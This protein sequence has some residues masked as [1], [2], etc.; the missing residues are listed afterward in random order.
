MNPPPVSWGQRFPAIKLSLLFAVAVFFIHFF[1]LSSEFPANH[2]LIFSLIAIGLLG[3]ACF[4]LQY[5][6]DVSMVIPLV[7]LIAAARMPT[8]KL[9]AEH[10]AHF[11]D[12][13]KPVV[14][15]GIIASD[16][17]AN[18][19]KTKVVMD[20]NEIRLSQNLFFKTEGKVLLTL[21]AGGRKPIA[22]GDELEVYG[23]LLKPR[24]ERNPG[25][26][27]YRAYLVRQ[28]IWGLMYIRDSTNIRSTGKN[29][30]NPFFSRFVLPIKHYVMRLNE[31]QLSP[32][33]A[34]VLTGLLVGERSEIP[35]EVIQAFSL[36]GTIHILSL[37]GLHVVFI[38]ALLLGI[39]SFLRIPYGW[40]IGMTIV[41]LGIY[42]CIGEFVP[43]VVRAALMTTVVLAGGLLQRRR[44]IV[45]SLFV[46]LLIILFFD[47]LSLFDIGLQLSF[48]AVLSIVLFY[49]KLESASKRIGFF[50]KP[51]MDFKDKVW[52]LLM[53][54]VAAQIG[55]VPFSAYYF[56]KIPLVALVSNVAVVPLSS[57]AM[58]LGFFAAIAGAFSPIMS[59][60]YAHVN[61]YVIWLMIQIAQWSSKWPLAYVEYYQLNSVGLV[62]FYLFLF[63]VMNWSN[64]VI[65]KIGLI[66]TIVVLMIFMWK[67]VFWATPMRINFL[68]VGQGD[69][70]VI[71]LPGGKTMVVDAGD[72]EPDFDNGEKIVAPF[73][74][75][76]GITTID[77]LVMS[78]P[79]D[80]HIGGIEYLLRNFEVNEVWESGQFYNSES[81]FNILNLIEQKGITRR[82]VHSG[83][84]LAIDEAVNVYFLHPKSGFVSAVSQAP[85]NTNNASIV[86]KLQYLQ[87]SIILTG[88]AEES[89]LHALEHYEDFLK[90]DILKASHHGSSNGLTVGFLSRV[91]PHYT[92]LSCGQFNKFNHPSPKVVDYL[93]RA[94]SAV[95]RTDH[96]GA[97]QFETDG[98]SIRQI[99]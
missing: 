29:F 44:N 95:W 84:F 65:R 23:T 21:R 53:V 27:D 79:H 88:D 68:D 12:L 99:R 73:L 66:V 18:H 19:E 62:T 61:E 89:S 76:A 90:S 31:Q 20:V 40:R 3:I 1:H 58:G 24:N 63:Y 72:K 55:T 33:S 16:P 26:F 91:Q 17:D 6:V 45:N 32:L 92:I 42:V 7:I 5:R 48:A 64:L 74:R 22:Y 8:E 52:S 98:Y 49:P 39:F 41:C 94:G 46:A 37:S 47:P 15:R 35:N 43:S 70:T 34:S 60:W 96:H 77:Y 54:S 83:D 50:K 71:Q 75:R 9:P 85:L 14:L 56:N 59:S 69:C 87:K 25:E 97:I 86:M 36:S 13:G 38:S 28:N 4:L 67:P 93:Y 57:A 51:E 80:D 11:A 30:G 78:H 81:Y 2:S 10:I 82:V